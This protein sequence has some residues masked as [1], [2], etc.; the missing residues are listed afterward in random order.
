MAPNLTSAREAIQVA[1][2]HAR[3]GVAFYSA[4]VEALEMALIQLESMGEDESALTEKSR[5][6][7]AAS[8]Q[9]S[10]ESKRGR[11]S[12]KTKEEARNAA[13]AN[14]VSGARREVKR[15]RKA[16]TAGR[17]GKD[18]QLPT[19]GIDFWLKLVT[20]EPRSAVEIANAAAEVVGIRPD[21]KEA[22]QKLK[23]R[24]APALA[25]LVSTQKIQNSGSGRERRFFKR[26]EQQE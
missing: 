9:K 20:E 4:R 19:T 1:L 13:S 8:R 11:Q 18:V 21:Q 26:E 16:G 17:S 3:E 22:I 2:S 6:K 23:Q 15:G 25:T 24:V 10:G 12:R 5:R 14:G 7:P